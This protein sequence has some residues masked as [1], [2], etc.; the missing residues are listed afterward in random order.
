MSHSSLLLLLLLLLSEDDESSVI[1]IINGDGRIRGRYMQSRVV[2]IG[3]LMDYTNGESASIG[4]R[5]FDL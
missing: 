4:A 2:S 1:I 5:I 3:M